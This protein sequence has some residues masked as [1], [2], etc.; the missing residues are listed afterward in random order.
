MTRMLTLVALA[1]IFTSTAMAEPAQDIEEPAAV[2]DSADFENQ[3]QWVKCLV[4][5]GVR[6]KELARAIHDEHQARKGGETTD[7]SIREAKHQARKGQMKARRDQK[8]K[9]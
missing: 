6:G 5:N 2:C 4:H 7:R 3:G 9:R 1:T 8:T